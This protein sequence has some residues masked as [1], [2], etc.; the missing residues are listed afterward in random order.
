MARRPVREGVAETGVEA[1]RNAGV[2]LQPQDADAR[3]RLHTRSQLAGS[4]PLSTV[5]DR[6][7]AVINLCQALE[8]F[9]GVLRMV[10]AENHGPDRR[11]TGGFHGLGPLSLA[12]RAPHPPKT[13][14]QAC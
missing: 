3:N 13:G 14:R 11:R 5:E 2:G 12:T 10:V 8:A 7:R 9:D 6:Q 4:L 1:A